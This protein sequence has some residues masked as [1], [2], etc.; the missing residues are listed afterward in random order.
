[1]APKLE[2]LEAQHP[3]TQF[4]KVDVDQNKDIASKYGVT[5]MPTVVASRGG[6][7]VGRVVG[8][9]LAGIN[10]LLGNIRT[11]LF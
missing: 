9:D 2:Q 7:E 5:A 4:I 6:V 8:A 3:Q 10:A 1:M 11:R